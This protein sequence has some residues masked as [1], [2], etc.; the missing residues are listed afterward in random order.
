MRSLRILILSICL[1]GL[2]LCQPVSLG[3]FVIPQTPE[4]AVAREGLRVLRDQCF[5]CHGPQKAKG[6]LVLANRSGILRGGDEGRVVS[7]GD[8]ASSKLWQVLLEDGDPHMP[9]KKQ[10]GSMEV[11]AVRRWIDAGLLWEESVLNEEPPV[12]EVVLEPLPPNWRPT[13]ALAFSPDGSKLAVGRG[14]KVEVRDLVATNKPVVAELTAGTDAVRSLR[15][16]STGEWLAA[17]TFRRIVLWRSADWGEESVLEHGLTGRLAGL[18]FSPDNQRLYAADSVEGGAGYLRTFHLG[19]MKLSKSWRAHAEG[20]AELDL[21]ADGRRLVTAGAD[22]LVHVWEAGSGR[23]IS[24]LEGHSAQ[25]LSV[26]FNTNATQVASG[27][28]DRQLRVYDIATREKL[29]TLGN[30][31]SAVVSVGWPSQDRI[32]FA[33]RQSGSLLTYKNLKAHTGEQS[34]ASGEERHVGTLSPMAHVLAASMDGSMIAAGGQD[35]VVHLLDSSGK[36]LAK[37]EPDEA[38]PAS[39]APLAEI[40]NSGIPKRGEPMADG[41]ELHAG[42]EAAKPAGVPL[43]LRLDG[44]E[45]VLAPSERG[46]GLLLTAVAED[47]FELDVTHAADLVCDP[48]APFAINERR[49]IVPLRTGRGTLTARFDEVAIRVPVVVRASAQSKTQEG[50]TVSFVRDVLPR[51]NKAGC[52]AGSCHAKPE[53]QNGFKL[54]VFSYDPKADYEEIVGDSRA[55]RVFPA[56]PRESLLIQKPTLAVAHEGGRLFQ[57]GSEMEALLIRWIREG[58]PF[59]TPGEPSLSHVEVF[60]KDR[61]YHHGGLQQLRVHAVYADGSREDV[62]GLAQFESN[63]T[64]I[65]RVDDDGMLT[66]GQLTGQAVVVARFMG[67]VADSQVRVPAAELLPE[68]RYADLPVANFIDKLAHAHLKRMGYLPSGIAGD[69]QFLRR[70]MLDAVGVLPKPDEV[71]AFLADSNPDKRKLAVQRILDHPAYADHWANKWADLLR[72]NPDRVGVKSIFVLDQWLR[73]SFRQNKP[74]DQFVREILEV[75]GSNHQA[76]PAVIYRDRR[77]PTELTTMFSQLFLGVR[78]ECAKC[79]HH[80]NEKWAQEDFYQM[81]AFFGPVGQ[82]GAGLSP[83]I[84]AG[85]ETF[86]FRPGGQVKHPVTAAVMTPKAPDGPLFAGASSEDPRR[87]LADWLLAPDNPFFAKAAVNRVW[88]I[89]FGRGM[90]EPVDDF[91]ISNPCVNPELLDELAREFANAGYDFKWLMRTIM[92]SNLYQLDSLPNDTNL[93]DTRNF[94]RSYRRRLPA[95]VLMDAVATATGVPD[96]FTATPIGSRAS[97]AWSYKIESHFL[98]AFGRPNSSSDCP[99]ERDLRLSVVQSLHL[100]NADSLQRKLTDPSGKAKVLADGAL[101]PEGI[102]EELYL[103]TLSRPPSPDELNLALAAFAA[104]GATRQSACEDLLWALINTPEFVFNH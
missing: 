95:E 97:Q 81:A 5:S 64:E 89:F 82:K 39:L 77:E 65:V 10:L 15:W 19:A 34:S 40:S 71:R 58:M 25:V 103:S 59:E 88:A 54:T 32:L 35:G 98:N 43:A 41:R 18:R 100:M 72:P 13:L 92:E 16:S 22:R 42:V 56:S 24:T 20:V 1:T 57:E 63:D 47:G 84:S 53:G 14:N 21:S 85:K 61:R 31:P 51:M 33:L 68:S 90:V 99:C 86:Y 74:Y 102:V 69:A 50:P 73:E 55:R 17:G 87:H 4:Q 70:A 36:T 30:H 96:K 83:P 104:E 27:G 26:A 101:P 75:E 76:G 80:P 9:P 94:S 66:V 28:A 78:M 60:P 44:P 23:L 7:L 93:S 12:T 37:W 38:P 11:D 52:G 62:T 48:G 45:L 8:H 67:R 6:G 29:S 46:R 49:E 3:F 79:H 2:I 91:R